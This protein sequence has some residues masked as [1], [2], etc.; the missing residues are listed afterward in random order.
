[1]FKHIAEGIDTDT[2]LFHLHRHDFTRWFHDSLHDEELAGISKEAEKIADPH[3]SKQKLL[4]F[5]AGKY[6]V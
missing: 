2:W 5:I 6:T 4:S 1:M 3:I